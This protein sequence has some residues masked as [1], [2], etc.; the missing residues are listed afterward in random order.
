MSGEGIVRSFTWVH[1]NARH[2]SPWGLAHIETAE[3]V[4]L[5]GLTEG[6]LDIGDRAAVLR[7]EDDLP[8]YTRQVDA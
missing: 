7:F 8:V 4:F 1:S 6:H 5:V 2:P 3:G